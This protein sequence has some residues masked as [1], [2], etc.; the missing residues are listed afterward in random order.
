MK[1][2]ISLI[3]LFVFSFTL[4]S[5]NSVK[6]DEFSPFD[7][8]G[9]IKKDVVNDVKYEKKAQE[10]SEDKCIIIDENFLLKLYGLREKEYSEDSAP[11]YRGYYYQNLN[12]SLK[13]SS[14]L[15]DVSYTVKYSDGKEISEGFKK[16]DYTVGS[17]KI[18]STRDEYLEYACEGKGNASS[19]T[20]S[21]SAVICIE[22]KYDYAYGEEIAFRDLTLIDGK[23][24]IVFDR[25]GTEITSSEPVTRIDFISLDKTL[26]ENFDTEGEIII[27]ENRIAVDE[28]IELYREVIKNS[29]K[30]YYQQ[31]ESGLTAELTREI[32]GLDVKE[33][34][35][36]LNYWKYAGYWKGESVL[37]AYVIASSVEELAKLAIDADKINPYIFNE[38]VILCVDRR[39]RNEWGEDMGFKGLT[40]KDGEVYIVLDRQGGDMSSPLEHSYVDF[41]IIPK[42]KIPDAMAKEGKINI[43]CNEFHRLYD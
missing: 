19:L 5:C 28:K 11:Y 6:E 21:E 23:A 40:V 43:I 33:E 15:P 18:F 17:Y 13:D 25:R 2:I 16:I 37:G 39:E 26:V 42:D 9:D 36:L 24:C 12:A 38:N 14:K 27:V 34:K 30:G 29:E 31:F 32:N 7:E 10:N 1:K 3:V 41:L 20:D 22:R 4:I 8:T 35:I